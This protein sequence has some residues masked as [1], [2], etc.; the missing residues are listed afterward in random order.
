MTT[1]TKPADIEV[2]VNRGYGVTVKAITDAVVR[3]MEDDLDLSPDS[4]GQPWSACCYTRVGV[5]VALDA[6]G[7]GLRVQV[8]DEGELAKG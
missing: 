3:W 2:Q 7:R 4:A 6:Q 8:V 5:V 1:D